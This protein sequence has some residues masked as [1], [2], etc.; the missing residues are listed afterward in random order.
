MNHTERAHAAHTS[1]GRTP[2][3]SRRARE[4]VR[5]QLRAGLDRGVFPGAVAAVARA[6]HWLA[7]EAAGYAQVTPY[8]RLVTVDTIFD[9]ASLTKPVVTTTAILQMWTRGMID[10]DAPMAAYLPAFAHGGKVT[11]T[12]RHL[13]AHTSG[14][15]AW[16][17]LYLPG[18]RSVDDARARAC[19]SIED[20]VERICATPL[21]APPGSKVEYSDLGFIILGSLV[22]RL[23]GEPLDSY[24][25]R[26]IARPLALR[27]TRFSPPVSWHARCAAT[28]L[29]NAYERAKAAEQGLGR[30]FRWR[31][32]L[33]RGEVHDGNAW[34]LGRGV[35]GHA[36][37]FGTAADVA[38]FG[39]MLLRGGALD[40]VR[41]LAVE[42]V[43]EAARDQR[44]GPDPGRRGLG[45]ALRGPFFG[46]RAS[47]AAFGHTGFTGTSLLVDPGRDLVI[48]LLTN[49]VH[50]TAGSAAI[51]EFRPAFHDTVIEALGG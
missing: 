46:M 11:A 37:L 21:V 30:R 42:A 25:Y 29:G 51:E 24:A 18:P 33:L 17:M 8:R 15:P 34:H 5:A 41:I 40:G 13:L 39:M 9:L 6:H 36:G 10:L 43:A 2:G 4:T 48:V 32:H 14:L 19:R 47:G 45:W 1:Q 16:E 20:A 31:K 12:V 22:E 23:S 7:V 50:P 35:A 3:V 26:H 44:P 28:E 27:W 49:R 38:R